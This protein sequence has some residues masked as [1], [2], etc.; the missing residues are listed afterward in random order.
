MLVLFDIDGTLLRS[1]KAGLRAMQAALKDIHPGHEFDFA[2]VQTAGRLDPLI[3]RDLL[4]K[5]EITPGDADHEHFRETYAE[6]LADI[7]ASEEAFIS[8]PGT[9]E[10]VAHVRDHEQA[11]AA[12]L[13]GNYAETAWLKIEAAGFRREDF[14]FGTWGSE[15]PI[16]RGLPPVA[17]RRH[18]EHSGQD[19][20][21]RNVLIIGD[22]PADIDCARANGCRSLAVATGGY[23]LDELAAHEPDELMSDLSETDRFHGIIDQLAP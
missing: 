17:I 19:V 7:I 22:T 5:H 20:S 3:W 6:K 13:T 14:A 4:E 21:P 1:R 10:A 2:G 23:D 18:H 15:A 16:R 9:L 12:L 11:T 8:L